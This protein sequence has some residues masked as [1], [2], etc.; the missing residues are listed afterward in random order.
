MNGFGPNYQLE[1]NLP[2]GP[3]PVAASGSGNKRIFGVHRR[4]ERIRA[5]PNRLSHC[6]ISERSFHMAQRTIRFSEKTGKEIQEAAGKHGFSSPTAFIRHSVE[7]EPSGRSEELVG[8]EERLAASLE[9]V[10][11]E[12]FRLGRAQQALFAPCQGRADVR[13]RAGRGCYGRR[14]RE[15]TRP[16]RPLA[17]ERRSSDGRRRATGDAGFGERWRR[18]IN[19][20]SGCP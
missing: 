11:Q 7:Q 19:A 3:E 10:R 8:V 12:I 4:N 9:R 20:N 2:G 14:H 13:T 1:K 15:S 5:V 16:A 17:Q 6:L 18:M